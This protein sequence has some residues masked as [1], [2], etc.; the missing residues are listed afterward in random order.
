M[1]ARPAFG[2]LLRILEETEIKATV[3]LN[4]KGAELFPAAVK[5]AHRAAMKSPATPILKTSYCPICPAA[6]EREVI[7]RCKAHHRRLSRRRTHRLV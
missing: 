5:Q 4:A 6:E 2:V 3:C 1:A 7:G